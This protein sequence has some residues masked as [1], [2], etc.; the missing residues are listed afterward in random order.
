MFISIDSD[1]KV[2]V[3]T[4]KKVV[5]FFDVTKHIIIDPHKINAPVF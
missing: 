2:I 4:I 1:G 3:N 5:F